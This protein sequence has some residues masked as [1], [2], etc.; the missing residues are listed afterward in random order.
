MQVK[1]TIRWLLLFVYIRNW[2]NLDYKRL[3]DPSI[4]IGDY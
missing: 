1:I 3:L 2:K 4:S